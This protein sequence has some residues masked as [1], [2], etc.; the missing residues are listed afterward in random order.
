MKYDHP[1]NPRQKGK[2]L[3]VGLLVLLLGLPAAGCSSKGDISGKVLY[4]GRPMSAG[5][6]T[7]FPSSGKGAFTSR[8]KEDGSYRVEKVPVGEVK[9]AV[10]PPARGIAVPNAQAKKIAQAVKSG[11]TTISEEALAKMPPKYKEA[12]ERPS[13]PGQS[14]PFPPHYSDPEKSGLAYTVTGGGQ[15]HD[16]ELK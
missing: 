8:I 12:L 1:I 14:V 6:V 4:Q 11:Q 7:F 15:S 3:G 9:I 13:A 10:V 2:S 5:A 16:I